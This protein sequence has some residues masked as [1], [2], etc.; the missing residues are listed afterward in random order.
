MNLD[1]GLGV[2]NFL[3]S[4][5]LTSSFSIISISSSFLLRSNVHFLLW[6]LTLKFS[7]GS[8]FSSSLCRL[9]MGTGSGD[10][11]FRRANRHL[12]NSWFLSIHTILQLEVFINH[13][14]EIF[15]FFLQ[16][17]SRS[18]VCRRR[19][20]VVAL[21]EDLLGMRSGLCAW[22]SANELL[23]LISNPFRKVW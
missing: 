3:N 16:V 9:S 17:I 5:L 21:R 19:L 4:L 7:A 10:A 8:A 12:Y 14:F 1:I 2:V 18:K 6:I 20:R 15:V 13:F 23:D 11:L 22:P